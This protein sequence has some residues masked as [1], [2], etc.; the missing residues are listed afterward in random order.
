MGKVNEQVTVK[1]IEQNWNDCQIE[2]FSVRFN[3]AFESL[4]S[5]AGSKLLVELLLAH[6]AKTPHKSSEDYHSDPT[7]TTRSLRTL[8][9][10]RAK[11]TVKAKFSI[12]LI[13]VV[14]LIR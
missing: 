7:A 6:D 8:P 2:S 1:K 3:E 4:V 13:L 9:T 12:T 5:R 14:T 10:Q 11:V